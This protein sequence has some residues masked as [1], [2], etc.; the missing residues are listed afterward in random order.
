MPRWEEM[1]MGYTTKICL[2]CIY[3]SVCK[4]D[5]MMAITFMYAAI[6]S[7]YNK[8]ICIIPELYKVQLSSNTNI[9]Q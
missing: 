9:S 4:V 7:N 6:T 8:A 5:Y 1:P 3:V 2:S